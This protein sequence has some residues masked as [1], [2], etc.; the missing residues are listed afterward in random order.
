MLPRYGHSRSSL[1]E[2]VLSDVLRIIPRSIVFIQ[3]IKV[4]LWCII[5]ILIHGIYGDN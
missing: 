2:S 3:D 5:Y 4:K 1:T